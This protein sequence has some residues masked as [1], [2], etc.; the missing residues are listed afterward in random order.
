[1]KQITVKAIVVFI[2]KSVLDLRLAKPHIASMK[3]GA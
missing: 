3:A 1:M 2:A